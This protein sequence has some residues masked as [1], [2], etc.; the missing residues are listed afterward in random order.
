MALSP[1]QKIK[2]FNQD[3]EKLTEGEEV[4]REKET[5]LYNKIREEFKN[6][7]LILTANT[8]KGESWL[9]LKVVLFSPR[10]EATSGA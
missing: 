2:V 8:Q 4:V 9:P 1:F 5:R 7:V 10:P 6:W 3:I